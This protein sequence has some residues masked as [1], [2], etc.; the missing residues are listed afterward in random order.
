MYIAIKKMVQNHGL[1]VF[2]RYLFR[3][4]KI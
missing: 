4:T 3:R 1:T 2:A